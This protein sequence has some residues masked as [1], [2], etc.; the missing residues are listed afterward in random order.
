VNNRLASGGF[1]LD[2]RTV[3][4]GDLRLPILY[5]LGEKDAIAHAPSIR[6]IERAAPNAKL[7]EVSVRAG[8]FGLVVGSRAMSHT[9]PTVVE[10]VR[11]REGRGTRPRLL[12][13][14]TMT[15]PVEPEDAAF[16]EIQLDLELFVGALTNGVRDTWQ[17]LGHLTTDVADAVDAA[18]WQVPRLRRLRAL[19]P[20]ERVSSSLVLAQQAERIPDKTF[21]LWMGRAFTYRDAD[22]RVDAVVRGLIR[23]GVRPDDR[24]AVFMHS[25]PSLLTMA[26]ALIRLGAIPVLIDPEEKQLTL[27]EALA[28]GD[29]RILAVDPDHV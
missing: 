17:R 1:V 4:L 21:F 16:E 24:V 7:F 6:A 11:W 10:W 15:E 5:F 3:T 8:H 18:R 27:E 14:S 23:S 25:R 28:L 9:W 22:R 26:T 19:E 20:D 13:D 12:A 2:G 29:T